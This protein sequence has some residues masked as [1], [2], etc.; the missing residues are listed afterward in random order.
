MLIINAGNAGGNLC[1]TLT[2]TLHNA[3]WPGVIMKED[4]LLPAD[5][6][7]CCLPRYRATLVPP[8]NKMTTKRMILES[9]LMK[10]DKHSSTRNV[11]Q[12]A[13]MFFPIT[14]QGFYYCNL[15]KTLQ[16]KTIYNEI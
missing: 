3:F 11:K 16:R 10:F 6:F 2:M 15:R 5:L 1:L 12:R 14:V 13:F 8:G 7:F 9:N 4:C